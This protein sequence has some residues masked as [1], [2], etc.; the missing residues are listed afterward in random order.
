MASHTRSELRWAAGVI[1][2]AVRTAAPERKPERPRQEAEAAP[3]ARGDSKVFDG[4]AEA[5]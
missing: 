2:R 1:A 4:Y 3:V 5:A